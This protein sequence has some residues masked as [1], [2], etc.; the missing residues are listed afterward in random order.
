MSSGADIMSR[1]FFKQQP[2]YPNFE[3]LAA[4]VRLGHKYQMSQL[5][6]HAIDYL[7]D[8]FTH[9]FD[10][11]ETHTH[12][13]PLGSGFNWSHAIG[14]VN[15]ARLTGE[16]RMLPT[17]LWLCTMLGAD[18][19]KGMTYSDGEVERLSP[20]DLGLCIEGSRKLVQQTFL[21]VMRYFSPPLAD[22]CKAASCKCAGLD[23]LATVSTMVV[24]A[25]KSPNPL[26]AYTAETM[27]V[28]LKGLCAGCVATVRERQK[29]GRREVWTSLPSQFG[30]SVPG[31]GL[32]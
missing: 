4:C 18:A 9:K 25:K 29:T 13:L 31:W 15:L 10:R 23:V 19:T 30:L 26:L 28:F 16:T 32:T 6:G 24:S 17:A 11:W 20:E 7:Q 8:H 2:P 14:V 27:G 12:W 1:S 3:A 21:M 22:S 5:L